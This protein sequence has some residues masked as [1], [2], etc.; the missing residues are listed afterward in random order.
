MRIPHSASYTIDLFMGSY[1]LGMTM[2]VNQAAGTLL[3]LTSRSS[4]F[5]GSLVEI[6]ASGTVYHV[7]SIYEYDCI[8]IFIT[9]CVI[10]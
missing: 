8:Y 4:S 9:W 1:I 3:E 7:Y 2:N 10:I 6:N 5:T